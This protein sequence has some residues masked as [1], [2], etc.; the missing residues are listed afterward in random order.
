MK[1][2]TLQDIAHKLGLSRSTVSR[3]LN[4]HPNISEK[5]KKLV[6]QTA[7]EL[8]YV[9]NSFAK[10]L[11][12]MKSNTIG[13]IVPDIKHDFFSSL[14]GGAEEAA[15]SA[16]YSII[17]TQ[18]NEDAN[19]E[20][21]N[22]EVL[23]QQRVAGV[24][25]SVSQNSTSGDHFNRLTSR[26][27]PVVFFDRA[28]DELDIP[29]VLIDDYK[30][31]YNAVSY[32]IGKGRKKIAHFA[33]HQSLKI[34]QRRLEGYSDALKN[35]DIPIDTSLILVAGYQEH[36]GYESMDKLIKADNIP[37]AVFSIN[38]SLAI[39]AIQRIKEEG[40]IIPKD[41]SLIGFSNMKIASIVEPALTTVNQPSLEMGRI[42]VKL[43]LEKI[44]SVNVSEERNNT[45]IL[46]TELII[47][48]ST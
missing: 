35:N 41:I 19:R 2:A 3:A 31:A 29:R 34:Y 32:L 46:D 45:I 23:L 25:A 5:V 28:L 18:S 37:D 26:G 8:H 15:H 7:E 22:T 36:D 24:I 16:G 11:K 39:G 4:D 1:H 6:N 30:S 17:V 10:N 21:I 44:E 14:I 38:D 48:K 9:P 42:A 47:R 20:I 27:I 40:L 12:N 33:G 13:I 43:L